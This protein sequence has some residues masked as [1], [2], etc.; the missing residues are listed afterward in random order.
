MDSLQIYANYVRPVV[1]AIREHHNE[2]Y[3]LDH[4]RIEPQDLF[5]AG[6]SAEGLIE[7]QSQEKHSVE[8]FNGDLS[9]LVAQWEEVIGASAVLQVHSEHHRLFKPEVA[10]VLLGP[11][12][13]SKRHEGTIYLLMDFEYYLTNAGFTVSQRIDPTNGGVD[14]A[15]DFLSE[16]LGLTYLLLNNGNAAPNIANTELDYILG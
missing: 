10:E 1:E 5:L 8:D 12:F 4:Y 3:R 9:L 16:R 14:N 7:F 13:E 15:V 6:S 2:F 11:Y